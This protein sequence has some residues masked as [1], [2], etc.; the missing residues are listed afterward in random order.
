MLTTRSALSTCHL[1]SECQAV[2]FDM[3]LPCLRL[4]GA[5]WATSGLLT[6]H[7]ADASLHCLLDIALSSCHTDNCCADVKVQCQ[8]GQVLW[9]DWRRGCAGCYRAVGAHRQ[10]ELCRVCC[11][12]QLVSQA[13][14]V[15]GELFLCWSQ[16][17]Q[18]SVACTS[19][20]CRIQGCA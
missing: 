2:E 5:I 15:G 7:G 16:S 6:S 13:V 10:Q 3:L 8:H 11:A 9:P 19:N 17:A 12:L 1:I 20:Q 14:C 18:P 4:W